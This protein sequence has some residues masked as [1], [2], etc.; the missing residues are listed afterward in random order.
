MDATWSGIWGMNYA[1]GATTTPTL[2]ISALKTNSIITN[3][4]FAFGLRN[5]SGTESGSSFLDMGAAVT[6]NTKGGTIYYNKVVSGNYWWTSYIT[7]V[8]FGTGQNLDNAYSL[9]SHMAFTDSGTSCTYVPA[10]FYTWLVD[11][12]K[13]KATNPTVS[14]SWGYT[15]PCSDVSKLDAV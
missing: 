4:I 10:A 13:T 15:M 6:S 9:T 3:R 14:T 1:S 12:I 5:L 7:G 2:L 11:M 8:K